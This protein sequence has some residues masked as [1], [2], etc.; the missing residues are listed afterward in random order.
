MMDNK[1][2]YDALKVVTEDP[3]FKN[4]KNQTEK[5]LLIG[6]HHLT[7]LR[8]ERLKSDLKDIK[9]LLTQINNKIK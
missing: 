6:L 1:K 5:D 7:Y 8:D 4:L 2:L 9:D 3:E